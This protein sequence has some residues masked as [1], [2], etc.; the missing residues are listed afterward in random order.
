MGEGVGPTACVSVTGRSANNFYFFA[1]KNATHYS[2]PNDF[3]L[4]A[5]HTRAHAGD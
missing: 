1:N 4:T 2:T 3:L 5:I